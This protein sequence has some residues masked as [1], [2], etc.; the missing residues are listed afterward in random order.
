MIGRSFSEA[1]AALEKAADM[2]FTEQGTAKAS[3]VLYHDHNDVLPRIEDLAFLQSFT[4][5]YWAGL[6]MHIHIDGH[7]DRSGTA[8][9]N[10]DLSIR[11]AIAAFNAIQTP[12]E[13]EYT[14]SISGVG[15]AQ[16]AH[17]TEDGV[18]DLR[19]RRTVI[20]VIF[21]P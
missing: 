21:S 5:K 20:E 19:N 7:A 12:W 16:L 4:A 8:A 13:D 2:K 18:R 1:L 10:A 15:E 3:V 17:L 6:K 11:R 9:Y 14:I